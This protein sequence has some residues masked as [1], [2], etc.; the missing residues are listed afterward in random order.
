MEHIDGQ[1]IATI[2]QHPGRMTVTGELGDQLFGSDLM[3]AAF[4]D[5]DHPRVLGRPDLRHFAKGLDAPWQVSN[6]GGR[7]G[8]EPCALSAC[9]CVLLRVC[10]TAC[11]L[12]LVLLLLL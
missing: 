8:G 12:L 4:Y 10:V 2:S 6:E 7:E 5:Q 3:Q 11:V 9:A 1:D